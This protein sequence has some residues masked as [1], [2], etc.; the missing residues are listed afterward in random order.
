M[1]KSET[2]IDFVNRVEDTDTLNILDYLYFYN[3]GGVAIGDVNNDGLPDIYFSSNRESNKLYLN[4]GNFSFEDITQQAGV[5]GKGNWKTGVTIV[6]V[7][8]DGWQDIYVCEVG[9]HKNLIGKNEL[10]IN[11]HDGSFT[12]RA[13]EYGIDVEGF[14]TQAIFFR[15]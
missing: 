15:L 2:G 14:N 3:G 11:N 13:Q 1:D 12:E 6:D 7:N 9:K 8:G 5:A 10:F 4:K